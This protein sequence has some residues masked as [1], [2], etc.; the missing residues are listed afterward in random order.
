[1][2]NE[3]LSKLL[4]SAV[5]AISSYA[6]SQQAQSPDLEQ[7]PPLL[8]FDELS[9]LSS[10]SDPQGTLAVR[11]ERLLTTPF[12]RNHRTYNGEEETIGFNGGDSGRQDLRMVFWNIERGLSFDQIRAAFSGPA[13]FE[14]I[15]QLRKGLSQTEKQRIDKQLVELQAADVIVL[16]EVDWGMKRTDYRDVARELASALQ[17][18][19]AY[20]V[21]FVEVDPIFELNTQVVH[22]PDRQADARLQEDLRIDR[23][24]Y[25]GLHG[26]AI[27]SRYPIRE[28]RIFRLPVCHDWYATEVQEIAKLERAKRWSAHKLFR[29]RIE[30]EVRRGGRM[31]LIADLSVPALAGGEL[32]IVSAHLENKCPP[33]CRRGQMKALLA[34]LAPVTNPVVLAGDLNTTGSDNTPTSVRNEIMSRVTDYRFWISQAISKFHPL[35]M[36]QYALLPLHY[37]HGYRDPTAFH[38]PILWENRE[39]ALFKAVEA[40]RFHDGRAFDFRGVAWRSFQGRRG[41]LADSNERAFKGFIPTYSF[42]RDYGGVAGGFK[43]DWLFVKPFI[44]EPRKKGQSYLFA[45]EFAVTMRELNGAVPDRISDHPPLAVDLPL[46]TR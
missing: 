18:N 4:L 5:L 8:L 45:P 26:N 30:R 7:G 19:Y 12:L 14:R 23:E 27:L 9:T 34:N 13:E 32:T 44:T 24:R 39:R 29:H 31:A 25:H 35:G 37:F 38:F 46:T 11:L 41:T 17:M 43:L 33:G 42:T 20:G 16:N 36:F 21:E 2:R 3:L 28:A 40:F 1:M 22:L 6:I 15:A 10:T